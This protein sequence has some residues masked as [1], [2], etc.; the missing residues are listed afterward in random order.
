VILVDTS[1]WIDHL[2][3]SDPGLVALLNRND[4][5]THPMVVGELALGSLADRA[6][7]LNL[8]ANLPSATNASHAEVLGFIDSHS[9]FSRGLS[10]V[11]V[12]LL[13]STRLTLGARLWT[14]D[15]RLLMVA[16]ELDAVCDESA[17]VS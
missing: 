7:V 2:H 11:D 5:L 17:I 13:A 15:K 10:L 14:R 6:T 8:L 9:L 4:V 3:H 16:R 12:H 1:I